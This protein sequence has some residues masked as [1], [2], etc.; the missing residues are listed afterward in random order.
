MIINDKVK[1]IGNSRNIKH[2]KEKGYDISVGENIMVSVYDLTNGSIFEIDVTCDICNAEKKVKWSS[3]YKYTNNNID[4]YYCIKCNIVKRK[5]TCQERY[6]GNSPTC[7]KEVVEKIQK[8]NQEKYGN[9]CSLHG[10]RQEMTESIFIEKYGF[11]SAAKNE[12]VKA[13]IKNTLIERYG[14]DTPLKNEEFLDK[15]KKTSL[16]RYGFDNPSKS[17]EVINNIRETNLE[18]YGSEWYYQTDEFKDKSKKTI[19]ERYGVEKYSESI[20]FKKAVIDKRIFN[21]PD[22]EI[23]DYDNKIFTLKCNECNDSFLISTDVLYRRHK[24]DHIICTKC[25]KL[26]SNNRSNAE[27][28]ICKF[29]DEYNIKYETSVRNI[30]KGELDIFIES[31][32]IA[33]EH[34][35][36]F[37][38]SEYFKDKNYHI[39]KYK[40]CFEKNIQLIQIWEDEWINN[41]EKVKSIILNKLGIF[42]EKIYA[43]KCKIKLVDFKEKDIF[44]NDNHLQGT[45]K[46]STNIGLY[47]NDELISLMTF[48]K[49]KINAKGTFELIRFCNKKNNVVIGGAS[50]LFKYFLNTFK[51]KTIVSYSDN[52]ISNGNIYKVLNFINTNETVN[53]YWCDGKKRYH[54]YTFNKKRLVSKG[55][56][57]EKTGLEI[58]REIGY[59]RIFSSGIKTWVYNE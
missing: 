11:K 4:P 47:Y 42:E 14:I 41:R 15:L 28:Q 5:E 23:I 50:K 12:D 6:G 53:F 39:N 8:T 7:S 58:M 32:N 18:R 10:N 36:N 24:N 59:Y 49:R 22:I 55:Y 48:G 29:L 25:N 31:K 27:I 21:Y 44:L 17:E 38:H 43:R 1:I 16:E 51:V 46:S 20:N 13:K 9:N 37:W 2:F 35:G 3:Y 57:S 19:L 26:N 40:R 33:I 56:D 52:N 30:I 34:N 54:R 45:S